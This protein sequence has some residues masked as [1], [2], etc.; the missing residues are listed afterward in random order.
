MVYGYLISAHGIGSV[1]I[2]EGI[3]NVELHSSV[4]LLGTPFAL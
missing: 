4:T 1:H 3:I 2:W